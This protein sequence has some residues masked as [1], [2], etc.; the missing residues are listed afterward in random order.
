MTGMFPNVPRLTCRAKR[1]KVMIVQ[2]QSR[3][4]H[5]VDG[6]HHGNPSY[7]P[8]SYPPRNKALLRVINHWFPLIRPY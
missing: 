3:S 6:R 4:L 1:I 7:P 8:Q 5:S 2:A